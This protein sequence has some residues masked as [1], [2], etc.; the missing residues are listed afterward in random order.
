MTKSQISQARI[1]K[2][3]SQLRYQRT[4]LET[5]C[6]NIREQ[7]PVWLSFR[8]TY[9]RKGNCKCTQGF[10]HG[11][12]V[13]IYFKRKGKTLCRYIPQKEVN[14][15]KVYTDRYHSFQENLAQIRKINEKINILLKRWQRANLLK[16]PK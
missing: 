1:R 8:Y 4:L 10:P 3:I 12:F 2:E 9:C 13:Y 5:H 14:S 15:L 7:L 16:L 11:P 6:L